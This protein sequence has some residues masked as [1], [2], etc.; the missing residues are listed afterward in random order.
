MA[1]G[2]GGTGGREAT[3]P[4]RRGRSVL[5]H[6]KSY[7]LRSGVSGVVWWGV[8]AGGWGNLIIK[9]RGR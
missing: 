1:R 5:N 7:L 8:G 2:E 4:G 3:Q 9:M 6:I